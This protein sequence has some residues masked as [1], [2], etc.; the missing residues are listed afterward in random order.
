VRL[1]LVLK[2]VIGRI[3]RIGPIGRSGLDRGLERG[4][5]ASL[6]MTQKASLR[7][8]KRRSNLKCGITFDLLRAA[9]ALRHCEERARGWNN[10]ERYKP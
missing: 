4:F 7:G 2:V 6:R 1:I 5:F 9:P 8:A 3:R 10:T